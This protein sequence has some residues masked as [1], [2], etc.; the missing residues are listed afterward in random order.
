MPGS[1]QALEVAVRAARTGGRI[2]R[3]RLGRLQR[4]QIRKKGKYD[5]VTDADHASE[6]AILAVLRRSFP[7]DSIKAEESAPSV[8]SESR[9]WLIDPLD[10]TVN[11]LHGFPM[12]CVSIGL[13]E[14]GRLEVGVV[15]DPTREE[16]F[17]ARR[18]HGAFLNGRRIRV[19]A[20]ATFEESL[21]ATGFPFRA[22]DKMD[23]YIGSFRK[24][25]LQ[26]GSIRR[27]G[28]AALDLAYVACGRMDGFW[29]MALAPW[30][31]A[32][33]A[34]LIREAGGTVS[35]FFG[36]PGFLERGHVLA[37]NPRIHSLMLRLL[38]PYFRG[39]MGLARTYGANAT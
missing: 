19:T 34:L 22:R 21:I 4:S 5:W 15:Y 25:F 26:T 13:M 31:M 17:T 33:G 39:K 32:A 27:A 29:E 20:C 24:I 11:F 16:L 37:G 28:A 2:L 30:D 38:A 9:Q 6:K 36:K 35:D 12:F 8:A 18:G 14:R 1:E 23:L 7:R 3:G 10:G